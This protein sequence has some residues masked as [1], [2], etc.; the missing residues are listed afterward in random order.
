MNL[1]QKC[2]HYEVGALF[3]LLVVV[4][5]FFFKT[6]QLSLNFIVYLGDCLQGKVFN[7]IHGLFH[8][9]R[10]VFSKKFEPA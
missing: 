3:L 7:C 10:V 2:T 5:S 8:A 6:F 4:H 1:Y 9:G